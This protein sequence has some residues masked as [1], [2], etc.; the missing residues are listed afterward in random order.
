MKAQLRLCFFYLFRNPVIDGKIKLQK[1]IFLCNNSQLA[2]Q[3]R[4]KGDENMLQLQTEQQTSF[5]I[6]KYSDMVYRYCRVQLGNQ[7]DAED[8][9][10]DTFLTLV[11]KNPEFENEEHLKAWLLK[12]AYYHCKNKL[13]F[14]YRRQY[15]PLNDEIATG[16]QPQ[17]V[18]DASV[19]LIEA[20][21]KLSPKYS[22]VIHLMYYE[23]YTSLQI[24]QMLDINE[25][26]VRVRLKRGRDKL[27]ELITKEEQL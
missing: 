20:L 24:A 11:R 6:E 23:G 12:T 15:E 5:F 1:F 17:P 27:K 19:R 14:R 3:L 2:G 25:S 8:A 16:D 7:A 18:S 9:Y 21:Q 22:S 10:Q 4:V 13:R 26:T